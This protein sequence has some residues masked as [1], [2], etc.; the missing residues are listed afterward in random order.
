MTFDV[1]I[2]GAGVVGLAIAQ[3]LARRDRKLAVLEKHD[4]FGQETSS[5][6]SEVIH[7]GIYYPENFLKSRLCVEGNRLLYA[8]CREHNIPHAGISKLIVATTEEE[9]SSL[10]VTR[11]AAEQKGVPGLELLGKKQLLSMEPDVSALSALLSPTTGIIDSHRLMQSLLLAAE[12]KGAVMS[13]RAKVTAIQLDDK[14]YDIEINNGEYRIQTKTVINSAGLHADQIAALMGIDI[15]ARGYRLK[16]CKGNYFSASPAPRLR[17]LVYPVPMKNNVGLGIHAT[18]D[19]TGR[20][21][22]GPD[23]RYLDNEEILCLTNRQNGNGLPRES[24][25][26]LYKVDEDHKEAFG[27]AIRKYLPGFDTAA[28]HPDMSGIRPKVQGPGDPVMDFII[29]EESNCGY[30]GFINLIGIES[31]GLTAC[32]AI[33]KHIEETFIKDG[34]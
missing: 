24:A 3:K 12:D 31:P 18:L 1:I 9:A 23:S 13:C 21:R 34:E 33:A 29:R 20:V 2:I 6:N 17:H 10:E 5:R 8:W 7:A 27:N 16:P 11:S 28:L 15:D 26:N 22:F 4:R 30:P 19:L 14:G 32:L 25:L